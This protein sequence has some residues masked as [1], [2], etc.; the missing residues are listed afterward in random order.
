MKEEA[1]AKK[2]EEKLSR[3]QSQ[4]GSRLSRFGSISRRTDASQPAA[5]SASSPESS[6][7][8]QDAPP[9][10]APVPAT[11][12]L[13]LSGHTDGA[14]DA[15]IHHMSGAVRTST[16]DTERATRESMG[17]V[18]A[19]GDPSPTVVA[20]IA[21]E[22]AAVPLPRH[23]SDV[24][25]AEE[26]NAEM[27][28]EIPVSETEYDPYLN[29]TAVPT[30]MNSKPEEVAAPV[31][32]IVPFQSDVNATSA[33]VAATGIPAGPSAP[34]Q[35]TTSYES[36]PAATPPAKVLQ[37]PLNTAP[38][39]NKTSS[40]PPAL[41]PTETSPKEKKGVK[42]WLKK[43]FRRGS[44]SGD[45]DAKLDRKASKRMSKISKEDP[46]GKRPIIG[47]RKSTRLNSSHWE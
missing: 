42:G 35:N 4:K 43:A 39:T 36:L 25:L 6:H 38:G 27:K 19:A 34:A 16:T 32:P 28:N 21:P 12:P 7:V 22:P 1:K 5:A 30:S 20:P 45:N 37:K 44:S 41:S 29:H 9:V 40:P 18:S 15:D 13:S 10:L 47:D 3:K 26:A 31:V 24:P 23:D 11:Q 14:A 33:P 8:V 46:K 17:Y 2:E